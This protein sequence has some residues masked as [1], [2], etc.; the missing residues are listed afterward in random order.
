MSMPNIQAIRRLKKV[1][2]QLKQEWK[3][4]PEKDQDYLVKNKPV[5]RNGINLTQSSLFS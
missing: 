5:P 2:S 3:M 4:D 1:S